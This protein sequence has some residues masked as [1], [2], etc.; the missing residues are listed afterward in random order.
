M[1]NA[2][3]YAHELVKSLY[4]ELSDSGGYNHLE[5]LSV[6]IDLPEYATQL[7]GEDLQCLDVAICQAN[8]RSLK[9]VNVILNIFTTPEWLMDEENFLSKD[10]L[11]TYLGQVHGRYFRGLQSMQGLIFSCKVNIDLV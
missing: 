2:M 8:F 10:E 6:T 7:Y 5:R 1:R 9:A 4:H 3:C 11:A